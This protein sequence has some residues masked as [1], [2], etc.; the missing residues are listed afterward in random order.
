MFFTLWVLYFT[1]LVLLIQCFITGFVGLGENVEWMIF[2]TC[3]CLITNHNKRI[4]LC[5]ELFRFY[6]LNRLVVQLVYSPWAEQ[7]APMCG[8]CALQ[9]INLLQSPKV[10][11]YTSES[12]RLCVE[13]LALSIDRS[14]DFQWSIGFL[15][16]N[17]FVHSADVADWLVV[18]SFFYKNNPTRFITGAKYVTMWQAQNV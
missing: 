15:H 16:H 6:E 2:N 10:A 3:H 12:T 11:L 17:H 5:V 14:V 13:I 4:L 7:K 1:F 9:R 8:Q 18:T